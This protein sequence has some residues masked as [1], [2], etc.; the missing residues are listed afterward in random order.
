LVGA[1]PSSIGKFGGD[2]D[3]WIWPRHTGD[4][5]LFRIYAGK[6]NEP[7]FY[8]EENVPYKP[9]KF[10]P[11]SMKGIKPGDF[12]MVFGF[13]G[14]T[15]EYIPSQAVSLIV[16]QRDPDR[17]KIR[18]KKLEIIY[19]GMQKNP[20]TRIQYAAKA[21]G[22]SN[23]WKKWQGEIKGLNR[24]N[25]V[26]KKIEFEK[27][28]YSWAQTNG[29]WESTYSAVFSGFEKFYQTYS[30]Y[31]KASDYYSE[32][33]WNGAEIFG[34][35][36]SLS[37]L[38]ESADTGNLDLKVVGTQT[39]NSYKNILKDLDVP[40]DERLFAALVPM[41]ANGPEPRFLPA[42]VLKLIQENSPE[43]LVNKVY[44]KSVLTNQSRLETIL[45]SGNRKKILALKN[46]PIIILYRDLRGF[47]NKN[48]S[49]VIDSL[50]NVNSGLLKTYMAGIME[51]KKG[52]P[53]YAD[54]N[55]TLRVTYG[56]VE[57]Y[58]PADGVVYNFSTTLKGIMEKDNPA[59]YD[60]NVPDRLKQLYKSKDFGQ[61]AVN[62]EVPVCFV[63]SNHTT[64]GNSGSPVVNAE[65]QLIG[66][67]FDRCWEGTMSDV[68]FD[69]DQCRNII[70][71]IRYALFIIDKFAGAGYL[72]NEMELVNK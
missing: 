5:A 40:T 3:N 28:F 49:P 14:S 56:K 64:G 13:P 50:D 47:Y 66:V 46:D 15:T 33:I 27:A 65:G 7:A 62:G 34:M 11:I 2:T 21:N 57:G 58:K 25:T 55:L 31:I 30:S 4:F 69:P 1:P 24:L 60:Y 37:N 17:I 16:N 20:K 38:I 9:K 23:S 63:A 42:D 12:T 22:I 10:F 6:N 72:L 29:L 54:A 18:D 67:N 43:N 8:S 51:M 26:D 52:Q 61:Y 19:Q 70:L 48:I 39:L 36:T 71:D 68:M 45:K 41:L 53:L 59:I 35:A 32:T 44:R